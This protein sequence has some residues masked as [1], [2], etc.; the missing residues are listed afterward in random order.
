MFSDTN[1]KVRFFLIASIIFSFLSC[2]KEIYH[3]Q[4]IPDIRLNI[5]ISTLN[6]PSLQT[7]LMPIYIKYA[8]GE[9]I[10]YNGHGI[11]VVQTTNGE[12]RAFDATC[13]YQSEYEDHTQL[14]EH[15]LPKSE[16]PL[17]VKCPKCNSEFN[18]INGN[19]QKGVARIGLK[20]YNAIFSSGVIRIFN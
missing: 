13:T 5:S 7:L 3:Q 6:N 10:G 16:N 12:Y 11:Y 19:I 9:T 1:T 2:E 15:L 20:E 4:I 8:N 17:I 18:L 14:K